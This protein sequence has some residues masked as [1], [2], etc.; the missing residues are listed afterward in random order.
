M[1]Q[2][3]QGLIFAFLNF[4]ELFH[5]SFSVPL[6]YYFYCSGVPVLSLVLRGKNGLILMFSK[7]GF[8]YSLILNFGGG[9]ALGFQGDSICTGIFSV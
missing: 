1:M 4:T 3:V 5:F 8:I 6:R 2:K 7:L 9:L